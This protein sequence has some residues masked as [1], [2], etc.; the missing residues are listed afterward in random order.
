MLRG[1]GGEGRE[2]KIG[3]LGGKLPA[4]QLV[5]P[6]FLGR[7]GH[8]GLQGPPALRFLLTGWRLK[9]L[10]PCTLKQSM[11]LAPSISSFSLTDPQ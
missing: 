7:T 11:G 6:V 4:L 10:N 3:E 5:L 2:G 8:L 9:S 1:G